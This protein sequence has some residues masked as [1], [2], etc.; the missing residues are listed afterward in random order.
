MRRVGWLIQRGLLLLWVQ[1]AGVGG[2]PSARWACGPRWCLRRPRGEP[3]NYPPIGWV[4]LLLLL[5]WL[6]VGMLAACKP[7]APAT[8]GCPRRGVHPVPIPTFRSWVAEHLD[9]GAPGSVNLFE[10]TIRILGGLLSAQAL[11]AGSHPRL[12]RALAEKATELGARLLPAFDSPSGA[13]AGRVGGP[14]GWAARVAGSGGAAP[15]TSSCCSTLCTPRPIPQACPTPTSACAPAR[16][17]CRAG[18]ACRACLRSARCRW[19]SPTWPGGCRVCRAGAAA[20]AEDLGAGPLPAGCVRAGGQPPHA[21]TR[22][23]PHPTPQDLG[24]R[25]L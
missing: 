4:L 25:A 5:P 12:S 8:A 18:A 11:S 15:R 10:T 13:G 6:P 16:G 19:S 23:C 7:R 3:V 1:V 20:A 21:L 24:P 22:A 17:R 9:V 2:L 14:H